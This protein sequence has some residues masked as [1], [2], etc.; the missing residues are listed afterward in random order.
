MGKRAFQAFKRLILSPK[1]HV[2]FVSKSRGNCLKFVA[3]FRGKEVVFIHDKTKGRVITVM[4]P[5]TAK[6]HKFRTASK[7]PIAPRQTKKKGLIRGKWSMIEKRKV[8]TMH[9]I[10]TIKEISQHLNRTYDSVQKKV[11]DAKRGKI[12]LG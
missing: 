11:Q 12:T 2:R 7:Q 1:S 6:K 10:F 5:K 9:P 3:L 8:L 4:K